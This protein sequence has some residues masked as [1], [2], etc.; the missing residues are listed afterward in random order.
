MGK[1]RTGMNEIS[2][3]MD[4]CV[5]VWGK[6]EKGELATKLKISIA[7]V[8]DFTYCKSGNLCVKIFVVLNFHGFI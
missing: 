1:G 4:V 5:R 6:R 8:S 3:Y 2:V 7:C